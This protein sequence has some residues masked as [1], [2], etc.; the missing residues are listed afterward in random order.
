MK[1]LLAAALALAA[2]C[3]QAHADTTLNLAVV[4]RTVFYLPAWMAEK[5]GF[6]KAEGLD[7][8]MKVYDGSEQIFVDLKKNEQQIALASIESVIAES[9]KDGKVRIVAG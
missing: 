1:A 7:V 8:R 5:K 4:S 3:S 2:L 9:Y 6:F